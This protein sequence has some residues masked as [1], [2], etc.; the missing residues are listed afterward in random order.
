MIYVI[1]FIC[2][3]QKLKVFNV[4]VNDIFRMKSTRVLAPTFNKS[5]VLVIKDSLSK[6]NG[7]KTSYSFMTH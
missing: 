2:L 5:F 6:L 1:M 7:V 4:K 3:Y